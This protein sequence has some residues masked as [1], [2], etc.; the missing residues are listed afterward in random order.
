MSNLVPSCLRC[1]RA[2]LHMPSYL[3]YPNS[4]ASLRKGYLVSRP[5]GGG[6]G[7]GT[8]IISCIRRLGTGLFFGFK[9]LNFKIF[10][11]FSEK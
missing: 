10:F 7:G 5:Q 9:I 8:L 4:G 1:V 6:G 2:L 11:W 3:E